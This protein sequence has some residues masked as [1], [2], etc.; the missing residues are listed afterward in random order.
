LINSSYGGTN[1]EAWIGRKVL[2]A[3]PGKDK[4]AD[5]TTMR[6]EYDATV[7][8]QKPA[9]D[10]YTKAVEEAKRE[11]KPAPAAKRFAGP[12]RG[13]SAE[14]NGMVAPLLNYRIRGVAWYQ[15]ES[16]GY[17]GRANNY[18]TLFTALIREWRAAWAE[19]DFPF[20]F[21]QLAPFRKQQED[22]NFVTGI[23]VIREA[24]RLTLASEPKCAMVV[25]TD[26][27][28]ADGDVHYKHKEPAGER[29]KL[30]ALTIAYGKEVE[31]SGPLYERMTV[32]GDKVILHFTQLGGGLIAKSGPLTGFTMAGEDQQFIVADARI[33]GDTVVV[34]CPAVP[35]PLAARY[36]WA[37]YPVV[38]LWNKA[39]LPASPFRTDDF[40]LPV[41]VASGR[42]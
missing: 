27:G 41:A 11:H 23:A 37:D 35:K 28:D 13:P 33:E 3:I 29:L 42:K 31:Y 8:K 14:Y 34:S 12:W 18:Q 24:Q 17:V 6:A 19:G 10:A 38:N 32:V 2:D 21:V 22:P 16:N 36:G 5:F 7:D 4:Y 15:G 30:A 39:G 20:L 25:T 40:P 9:K 26:L 1:V